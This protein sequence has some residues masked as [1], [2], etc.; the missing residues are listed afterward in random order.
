MHPYVSHIYF[1]I[2]F[3]HRGNTL[4]HLSWKSHEL[5]RVLRWKAW[6]N[7]FFTIIWSKTFHDFHNLY[8]LHND[9]NGVSTTKILKYVWPLFNI[10]HDGF[11]EKLFWTF[12]SSFPEVFDK[13]AILKIPAIFTCAGVSFFNSVLRCKLVNLIKRN[14]DIFSEYFPGKNSKILEITFS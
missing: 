2:P 6:K 3:V 4:F 5:L 12:C 7:E 8:P 1:Y 11:R 10:I 9:K 14:S 13:K